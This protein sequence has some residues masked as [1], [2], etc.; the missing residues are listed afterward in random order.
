MERG[1]IHFQEYTSS[2][3]WRRPE[4]LRGLLRYHPDVIATS[5][6]LAPPGNT[7]ASA[8]L[9][10]HNT[11]RALAVAISPFI[12]AGSVGLVP[13]DGPEP[14]IAA[15]GQI[16]F[17]DLPDE[18][19]TTSVE[20]FDGLL[21]LGSSRGRIHI[22]DVDVSAVGENSGVLVPCGVLHTGNSETTV[23]EHVVPPTAHA[24]TTVVRSVRVNGPVSKSSVLGV[25]GSDAYIWDLDGGSEP[26]LSWS[27]HLDV[28]DPP[29][30][31]FARWAPGSSHVVLTGDYDGSLM[32]VDTRCR[33]VNNGLAFGMQVGFA[34]SSAEF[35]PVIPFVFAAASADG[36][37]SIFDVRYQT[38][39][40]HR[41]PCLQGDISAIQWLRQQSD[42][43]MSS[44]TDGSVSMWNLR[45]P[46][47]YCVGRAQYKYP[48]TDLVTTET[49]VAQRAYGVSIGGELTLTGLKTEAMM[50][51]APMLSN[52]TSAANQLG[53]DRHE[54][55]TES[56]ERMR[57]NEKAACGL[58]YVRQ[59]RECFHLLCQCACDRFDVKDAN[60]VTQLVSLIDVN[61]TPAIDYDAFMLQQRLDST[62][63]NSGHSLEE[64]VEAFE[65][66]LSRTTNRLCTTI[67]LDRI[68]GLS[69]P[70]PEDMRRLEALG[71]NSLLHQVLKTKDPERVAV[72][73]RQALDL[74]SA[75]PES[76]DFIDGDIVCGITSFLLQLNFVEG[77]RFVN[78]LITSLEKVSSSPASAALTRRILLTAQEPYVSGTERTRDARRL[79]E[80]FLQNITAA[81]EAVL[82][83][84]EIQRLG[85]DH[86]QAVISCVNIYQGDCIARK[87]PGMFGW[88]GIKPFILFLHCLTADSNYVTFFWTS[89]QYIQAFR[90]FPEVQ[91]VESLLFS[92]VNRI[93]V[94]AA[95]I[96]EDLH[97][98]ADQD[99]FSI[100]VLRKTDAALRT[101]HSFLVVLLRVQLECENVAV[102]SDMKALPPVM[103]NIVTV[104]NGASE[105]VL[106]A[107]AGVVD[108]LAGCG[109]P[110]MVRKY[111]L[112]TVHEFSCNAEDLMEVSAKK[113]DDERLNEIL[114]VCDDF[115]D[116]MKTQ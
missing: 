116:A 60:M 105:D 16:R 83:Q 7:F 5:A 55:D 13:V 47:T 18:T 99:R 41:I 39:A 75:H 6:P 94:A 20:W 8:K 1:I 40:L 71:L 22:S 77:E 66:Q 109:Q 48:L 44:G 113:E 58:L 12:G 64:A 59:L 37:F 24:T 106:D 45:S 87:L 95:K 65:L 35:N 74:L 63:G 102:K 67:P 86:H 54:A 2:T 104:L 108:A 107:W 96:A 90:T 103:D 101:A 31:M 9:A 62:T 52:P 11:E 84:L 30:I 15:S 43:L 56:L 72:G 85:V 111:C 49:F 76:F 70:D 97:Q 68:K 33:D 53:R 93:H 91:Q 78:F 46:P 88:L 26:I 79:E 19:K 92:V 61:R 4:Q 114:D 73:V 10:L 29:V 80:K 110:D 51:M 115:F 69:K 81:K 57:A 17:L 14:T 32:L 50:A 100:P 38:Q 23:A 25:C 3:L 36:T 28:E 82:T 112:L 42:M 27:P 34:A 98:I 89:V 21:L